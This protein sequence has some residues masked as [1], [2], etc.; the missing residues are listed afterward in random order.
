LTV[1][2]G[3]KRALDNA[4]FKTIRIQSRLQLLDIVA[5]ARKE[6]S[7]SNLVQNL[8]LDVNDIQ[9]T[10]INDLCSSF[11]NLREL[12]FYGKGQINYTPK[13]T[14]T[15]GFFSWTETIRN[16]NEK[17]TRLFAYHVLKQGVCPVLTEIAICGQT[18]EDGDELI[19][20]L[21]NAPSLKTLTLRDYNLTLM[22]LEAI[23]DKV[24][25]LTSLSL[26]VTGLDAKKYPATITPM[27]A[28][29]KLNLANIY[30]SSADEYIAFQK[31]LIQKYPMITDMGYSVS[32]HYN[33]R[34][35]DCINEGLIPQLQHIAPNLTR[36]NL[37]QSRYIPYV[38]PTLDQH[39]CQLKELTI[40][41]PL[42]EQEVI[43]ITT[44][45]QSQFIEKLSLARVRADHFLEH[46]TGL[47]SLESLSFSYRPNMM[48]WDH[49]NMTALLDAVGDT[50]TRL[51]IG[52]AKL[53][54]PFGSTQTY[55]GVHT[56]VL[57]EC[58]LPFNTDTF[59]SKTF[60]QLRNLT[61]NYCTL[62]S[63]TFNFIDLNLS[64]FEF[65][66]TIPPN[67]PNVFIETKQDDKK[68]WYYAQRLSP[69]NRFPTGHRRNFPAVRAFSSNPYDHKTY[70][71][72]RCNSLQEFMLVNTPPPS[73]I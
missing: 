56:L 10:E 9:A 66:D 20:I 64:Y 65:R 18:L 28:I 6:P 53:S 7:L 15:L 32:I 26:H 59:I 67:E 1:S 14:G 70:V 58:Y 40:G 36:L 43:Q 8:I 44:S 35:S 52:N 62:Y 16:I 47:T 23:H 17:S 27:N 37:M 54:F 61:I 48:Q 31:Y 19:S 51:E 34:H 29:T 55:P 45:K 24:P 60:P 30:T 50:I 25:L 3:W 21:G 2:R 38:F 39:E 12:T 63:P 46:L 41:L 72:F 4:V 71:T 11:F 5:K 69:L 33:Q 73:C 49:I 57:R 68:R 13:F 22:D 42:N